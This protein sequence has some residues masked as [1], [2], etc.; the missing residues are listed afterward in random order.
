MAKKPIRLEKRPRTPTEHPVSELEKLGWG[1]FEQYLEF[2]DWPDE[3]PK[4]IEV[5][6]GEDVPHR[7][8]N[9]WGRK[10]YKMTVWQVW[11]DRR[12][13]RCLSSGKRL[14]ATIRKELESV[15]EMPH[16]CAMRITRTGTGFSTEYEVEIL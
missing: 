3:D 6:L 5:I 2:V 7:Y 4:T 9:K 13:K 1:E 15:G 14:W 8:E 10:Q 16:G 12:E 11:G